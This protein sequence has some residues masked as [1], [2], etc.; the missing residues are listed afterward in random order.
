VRVCLCVCVCVCA[1]VCVCVCVVTLV[2]VRVCVRACVRVC[3]RVC[4]GVCACACVCVCA[5][6]FV[7]ARMHGTPWPV[8]IMHTRLQPAIRTADIPI[9][10]SI[11]DP[12][13]RTH[14]RTRTIPPLHLLQHVAQR[15][16]PAL[17][18]RRRGQRVVFLPCRAR[19]GPAARTPKRHD[20]LTSAQSRRRCGQ[21]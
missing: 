3:V 21:G 17:E 1:C 5:C 20:A 13:T 9:P 11:Q 8:V 19:R 2:C 12:R 10:I 4:E 6:A 7:C 18:Q 15:R 14:A 16:R